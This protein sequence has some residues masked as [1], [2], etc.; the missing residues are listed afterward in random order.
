MG[1]IWIKEM[2]GGLDARRMPET[3]PGGALLRAQDGHINSGGEFEQRAAFKKA[4]TLPTGATK[5]LAAGKS[6]L[7]VF[8]E[9][10]EPTMPKGV[11]YQRLQRPGATDTALARI[12]STDLNAGK[13]YAIAEF[14]DGSRYHFYDGANV[15]DWIDGRA[16]AVMT[17]SAGS[18]S[19][20]T[21][22][23]AAFEIIGGSAGEGNA[24]VNVLVDGVNLLTTPIAHTGSHNSTAAAIAAAV[25]AFVTVPNYAAS[26]LGAV[27][28]LTGPAGDAANDREIAF[29]VSGDVAAGN[30]TIFSGGAD[31]APS[32]LTD[33]KVDGVSI[34]STPVAWR[35][36]HAATAEAIA[37]NINATS[38]VPEYVAFANGA[39]VTIIAAEAGTEADEREVETTL[40]NGL[41]VTPSSGIK[42]DDGADTSSSAFQS[43]TFV[44]TID[45]KMYASGGPFWHFSGVGEPT[46]WQ[47][48]DTGAGA[49]NMAAVTSG[50]EDLQSIGEYANYT[51]V[52]GERVI[53]IW[54]VDADPDNYRRVQ[55]LRNTGTRFP[56]TPTQF[57]DQDLFYLDE[58]GLRSLRARDSS[59]AAATTDIGNPVDELIKKKMHALTRGQYRS[60]FGLIEPSVGRFWLVFPDTIFVLSH[61]PGS[62]VTAW[63][64]YKP[65]YID[66][67]GIEQSFTIDTAVV[68]RG[69]VWL[70]SGDNIFVYG[71]IGGEVEYDETSPE[72]WL[73]Y[74]DANKPTLPKSFVGM[75]VACEG[76]WK[77]TIGMQPTDINVSDEV[78]TVYRTSFNAPRIGGQGDATH[79]SLR[80]KGIGAGP[81][82]ISSAVIHYEANESAEEG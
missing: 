36:S 80:F 14:M 42:L 70:R 77:V 45:L 37:E 43:A 25:N 55:T 3:T 54:A 30:A 12:L 40:E 31:A 65:T 13:V 21:F 38:S 11:A 63:S 39:D 33:L 69:K 7:Y 67:N 16:R 2:V 10:E 41:E 62:K 74:L 26:A 75:D 32:V 56:H 57:G 34:I 20:A 17:I 44:K 46:G 29:V 58:S 27:V 82:K 61:F 15:E 60:V 76:V 35:D 47:T 1:T 79:F 8:G 68:Y 53:V 24:I 66:E 52:F 73:P 22:A 49:I 19:P 23:S 59:S 51:A 5:G 4:Y 78:A 6:A 28:T 18:V 81:R 48:S 50:A 72:L 71:G 9:A 64:T